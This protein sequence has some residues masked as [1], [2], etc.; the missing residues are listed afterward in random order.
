MDK[1]RRILLVEDDLRDV[2]LTLTALATSGEYEA[3]SYMDAWLR[4]STDDEKPE[5]VDSVTSMVARLPKDVLVGA[6]QAMRTQRAS[7]GYGVDIERILAARLVTIATSSGD[8]EL[9]RLLLDP[10]GGALVVAGEA[11]VELGQLATSRRGLNVVDGRTIGLLLPTDSP[12]L[13]DESAD[14]LR[15]VM[16]AMG[17]PRGIRDIAG[18][19]APADDAGARLLRPECA[20]LEE[21][22]VR[23][24]TRDDAGSAERTEG[25]LDELAGE[26][27]SLVI[28]GLDPKAATRALRWGETRGVAVVVLVPPDEASKRAFGF[29]LGE[30]RADVIEA[31][32]RSATELATQSVV[33]VVDGSEL[34]SFSAQGGRLGTLTL[35][36]VVSC[37]TPA[38]RAGDPRFP[39]R[40]WQKQKTAAW[41]VT[42]SPACARDLA[43]E[44]SAQHARGL[45]ALTLEAASLPAHA[46]ELRVLSASAGVVPN[47]AASDTRDDELRR[48]QAT[49]G[50]VS[51]WTALGRDA[52][53]LA[54]SAVRALPNGLASDAATVTSRRAQA[55]DHLLAGR[56]RLWTTE[57]AGW[58]PDGTMGRTI[59]AVDAPLR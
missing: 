54:R 43:G 5:T 15:G 46:A 51:W 21:D 49:L 18:A 12:G 30:S 17:L 25:S 14:V 4:A 28:A 9:A 7:F 19:R 31:L 48:F 57:S 1:F 55:R 37:D 53:T 8:A 32:A 40:S 44:L 39:V 20:T 36:P 35:L 50:D 45:M 16:W 41:L 52:A 56:A 11:G 34:D 29:V 22:Q 59:C 24:V 58:R 26:G 42:G 23:L 10:D 47:S 2:E 13:R 6:L 3:I 38:D 27:A 33:P